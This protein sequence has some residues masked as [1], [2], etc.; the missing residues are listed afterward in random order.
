[1]TIGDYLITYKPSTNE[2]L[3]KKEDSTTNVIPSEIFDTYAIET[4]TGL[5]ISS[6]EFLLGWNNTQNTKY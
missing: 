6:R 4:L 5:D 2:L 3:F 1:L